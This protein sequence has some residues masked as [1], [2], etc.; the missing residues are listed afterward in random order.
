MR[1]SWRRVR[2]GSAAC[3]GRVAAA[4]RQAV[5]LVAQSLVLALA[6]V[7]PVRSGSR[8]GGP[9]PDRLTPPRRGLI[10][11]ETCDGDR[12]PAETRAGPRVEL[13]PDRRREPAPDTREHRL[14]SVVRHDI[15][16][17]DEDRTGPRKRYGQPEVRPRRPTTSPGG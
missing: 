2:S 5:D 6:R 13:D 9:E 17:A 16:A 8:D 1:V 7:P 4:S 12:A 10:R 15:L 14:P 11:P 3:G